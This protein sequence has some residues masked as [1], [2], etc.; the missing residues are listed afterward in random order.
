MRKTG[1]CLNLVAMLLTVLALAGLNINRVNARSNGDSGDWSEAQLLAYSGAE[2]AMTQINA[3]AS[4]RTTYAAATVQKALGRG[5]FSWRLVDQ[6]DGNLTDDPAEPFVI[7]STGTVGNAT[8]TLR[9]AMTPATAGVTAG[10][11]TPTTV[12]IGGGSRVDSYDSTLGAY[13]GA[14]IG[15]LATVATNSTASGAVA[16]SGG[17]V[18]QGSAVVGVGG[19]PSSVVSVSGGG[20]MTG[21]KTAM[22]QAMTMPT[23]TSPSGLGS[24][25]G[26][27]TY[28]YGT[29]I[30][31]SS[32][33]V[34]NFTMNGGGKVQISGNV[35][36]L[37]DGPVSVGNGTTLEILP[38]GSL[39]FYFNSTLTL[40]GGMANKVNGANLSRMQFLNLG[41][42]AV[43]LGGGGALTGA[44]LSPNGTV[45]MNGGSQMYG[46]VVAKSLSIT[47]G[48]AFHEDKRMTTGTDPITTG[49]GSTK[50]KATAWT[51]VVN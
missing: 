24:S 10:V 18:L 6:T 43:T 12:L 23:V 38:G 2:H 44:I 8:C 17:S 41:T 42:G 30:I 47:N 26:N 9:V 45:T 48:A 33:H 4:W 28:G 31:A 14:N 22:S 21:T 15:S 7:L 20:S 49:A 46:A 25:T 5:T 51:Q 13:G 11:T 19:N 34:T 1:D 37:A 36:I 32:M 16:I 50:P 35:T 39:K 27:V 3:D 40:D 29:A